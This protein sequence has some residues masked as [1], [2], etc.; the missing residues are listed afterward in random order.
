MDEG[1]DTGPVLARA[2]LPIDAET[3][4]ATL[5][6]ALAQ[7]GARQLLA[8]LDGLA[9]GTLEAAPQSGTGVTYAHKLS[10]AEADINWQHTASAIDRQIRAFFPW[11]VAQ[12]RL[13]GEVV[14]LLASRIGTPQEVVAD[15]APGTL[16]GLNGDALEIA[17]GE[18]KVQALELQRA[19]RKPVSARDF[20]NALRLPA[21]AR[22]I[23]R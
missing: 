1:L 23:F 22:V 9:A 19:G 10:K 20:H 13:D 12:T 3:T 16:L 14:K 17:C 15:A 5:H 8:V 6:D 21:G 2:A 4:A 7:L 18:G 11:P